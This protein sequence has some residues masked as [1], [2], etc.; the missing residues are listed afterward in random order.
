MFLHAGLLHIISN[1]WALFIFG[2]GVEDRLGHF[3]FLLLFFLC[4][5]GSGLTHVLLNLDSFI[6][7]IGASGAVS[8]V[9]GAYLILF[10][11][12][13]ILTFIPLIII[14]VFLIEIY[15]FIFFW[16]W[17]ILQ[18]INVMYP[19]EAIAEIAWWAHIGGFI[20]GIIF[21]LLDRFLFKK[22]RIKNGFPRY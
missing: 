9:I 15:A 11:K 20:S 22:G 3:R 18:F 12:S 4:G 8:G 10:P 6:P 17:F 13:K 16:I 5:V 21:V 7:T 2:T 19:E 1:M 14:P